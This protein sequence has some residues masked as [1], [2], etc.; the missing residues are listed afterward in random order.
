MHAE[1]GHSSV[2]LDRRRRLHPTECLCEC[3]M[4]AEADL[5]QIQ[6]CAPTVPRRGD[7]YPN[8]AL[9]LG[10]TAAPKLSCQDWH[11]RLAELVP[12]LQKHGCADLRFA[13]EHLRLRRPP[14]DMSVTLGKAAERYALHQMPY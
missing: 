1:A 9:L 4:S 7:S 10:Q 3:S 2:H 5:C 12:T 11:S 6:F 13:L 8:T 14:A